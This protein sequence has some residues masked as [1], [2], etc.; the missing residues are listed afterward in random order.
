MS[1]LPARILIALLTFVLG[2]SVSH[3]W[4]VRYTE[5]SLSSENSEEQKTLIFEGT[6]MSIGPSVPASGRFAFYRLAKYRVERVYSGH[7]AGAEIVVDHLSLT[8]HELDGIKAGDRVCVAVE[9]S[10]K[11]FTRTNVGGIREESDKVDF[12]YVGGEVSA[13]KSQCR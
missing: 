13:G 1:R 8:T 4:V 3:L 2:V 6:V 11:I 12:F 5:V 10:K 9:R 7:Y